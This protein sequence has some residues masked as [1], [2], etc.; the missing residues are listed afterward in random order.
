MARNK[1][2]GSSRTGGSSND[3]RNESRKRSRSNDGSGG[4]MDMA[5][6]RPMAAAAVAAGA[7]AAGLFLWSKRSQISSQIS[8]L[9]DQIGEWA[10]NMGSGDASAMAGSS[11]DAGGLTTRS[12]SSATNPTGRTLSGMSGTGG[13]SAR[14]GRTTGG[15]AATSSASARGR[16]Q[17]ATPVQQ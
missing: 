16:A 6:E 12:H 17:P 15:G 9:G 14:P 8:N 13:G 10:Q 11:N 5:R 4:V 7:A 2:S 3:S 1:R